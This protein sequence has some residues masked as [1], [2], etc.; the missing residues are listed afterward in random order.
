MIYDVS[1]NS[2]VSA[3]KE[4]DVR[5]YG[6]K[7][8]GTTDD[9][10]AI[11]AAL[12]AAREGGRVVFPFGT[13]RLNHNI[14]F[15]S[16]QIIDFCGS[17]IL[18]GAEID[19]LLMAYCT[20]NVGGYDGVHDSKIMNGLFDGGNF[21]TNNT[22][23]ACCHAKNL[24]FENLTV[25]NGYGT[26]HD[27]EINSSYNVKISDCNFEA[28][29]RTGTSACM[30]QID[31]FNNVLTYPWLNG[32]IDNTVSKYIEVASCIFH[33]SNVSPGIGNHSQAIDE[34]IKIHDNV[35][36]GLTSTRGAIHFQSAKYVE[37]YNNTFDGCTKGVYIDNTNNYSVV[38][39]NRFLDV[40][41]AIGSTSITEWDNRINEQPSSNSV[42]R[43][44][45]LSILGDSISTFAGYI[46]SEN[47]T[48]YPKDDVKSVSDTW[49]HKLISGLD[50]TLNVNN[51]WSGSR[52]TTTDGETSA[53]CIRC[54]NLGTNPDVIIVY[55]GI[56]DYN[57]EVEL[58]TYDGKSAVPTVTTT[59]REAY[60]I[61]LDKILTAYPS[62]EVWCCTLPQCE[63]NGESGF[64]EINE[65]GVAL[66][67]Y[68]KAIEE[69]ADSFGVKVLQHHSCG[70]TYHN[71]S[72]FN[73][74]EL[75][76]NKKGHSL[77]ANNDLRQ[78]DAYVRIRY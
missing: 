54:E 24:I 27:I 75:H 49:W 77:I 71:M 39:N 15:Y 74:N 34:E 48:Y 62:A 10:T 43:G 76:P 20:S 9:S 40:E 56:N 65:N 5:A 53:G 63:R 61:M 21:T 58:G 13:Y 35:F 37:V 60:A 67:D 73:P 17:T 38:H 22:L 44:K 4:F 46:P 3:D 18:Q 64:P 78:M 50:M 6:A 16:N 14:L 52:V 47:L 12:D 36:K 28:S 41:I 8:D 66:S 23:I 59:F 19:N 32:A 68:N 72:V 70:L 25:K 57:N 29:R 11:Q 55:M 33:D 45:T 30:V 42:Y 7:G 69:L 51:S 31:A 2:V 26:W 1:G